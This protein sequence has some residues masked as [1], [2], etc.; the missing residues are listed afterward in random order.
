MIHFQY[1]MRRLREV[2]P[3]NPQLTYF[4]QPNAVPSEAWLARLQAELAVAL[5]RTRSGQPPPFIGNQLAKT[6]LI[7]NPTDWF[8]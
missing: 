8:G 5:G 7:R 2:E 3:N 4:A 1:L 6:G